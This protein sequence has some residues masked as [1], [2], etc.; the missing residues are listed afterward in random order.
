MHVSCISIFYACQCP[1]VDMHAFSWLRLCINSSSNMYCEFKVGILGHHDVVVLLWCLFVGWDWAG[2]TYHQREIQ[3]LDLGVR[4]YCHIDLYIGNAHLW[5]MLVIW[6][7]V[8]Y[9][10]LILLFLFICMVDAN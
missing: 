6:I 1:Y 7:G 8:T 4:A 3:A 2:D 5:L 9:I 10:L